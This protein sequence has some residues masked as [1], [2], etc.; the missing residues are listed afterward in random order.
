MKV[1]HHVR[2]PERSHHLFTL[3]ARS[4]RAVRQAARNLQR[5]LGF[6]PEQPL[7]D[8]AHTLHVGQRAFDHRL[9][10]VAGSRSELHELLAEAAVSPWDGTQ[11]AG[12]AAGDARW[13]GQARVAFLFTGQIA[14]YSGMGRSLYESSTLVRHTFDE[15]A[16]ILRTHYPVPFL[17][18]L[19]D[20]RHE[21][22]LQEMHIAQPLQF[23]LQV[24]LARL[25][26]SW[27]VQPEVLIGHS[28]GEFAA[29]C[30]AGS[31]S[32]HDALLLVMR[33]GYLL[34]D[35][36][37]PGVMVSL[38]AD[39]ETV[40]GYLRDF[41]GKL[42]ITNINASDQVVV[43]GRPEH[44]EQLCERLEQM[45]VVHKRVGGTRA[46]HCPLVEPM[47]EEFR[48]H[49]EA[50]SM[51][52]PQIP[53]VSNL[54]GDVIK[55][56]ALD[57]DYWCEHA[58][59]PVRFAKGL[60][61]LMQQGVNVYIEIGQHTVLTRL[62][63]RMLADHGV[64]D[65]A[66]CI[67][68]LRRGED[69][70]QSIL[71][72]LG[73]YW[74]QGGD[75]NW[76]AFDADFKRRR[77]H[78]PTYPFERRSYWIETQ[79]TMSRAVLETAAASE[80]MPV[81][82]D[83]PGE[84]A[85]LT[86]TE[87]V[88][89]GYWRDVIGARNVRPQSH[90]FN[91][92]GD[93]LNMIQVQ[94]RIREQLGIRVEIQ[95]MVANPKLK[96]L[97][98]HVDNLS[99]DKQA[100]VQKTIPVLLDRSNCELSFAQQ[101]MWLLD[102][103]EPGNP[104][105]N[106]ATSVV[107]R[108]ALRTDLLQRGLNEV[109][110]RHESLRTTFTEFNMNP[111]QV[112]HPQLEL[113]MPVVDLIDLAAEE[114]ETEARRLVAEEAQKPFDLTSGPLLRAG[115]VRLSEQEHVLLLTMHHIISD[116]WSLN[117]LVQE[118]LS[119]YQAA[120]AGRET[121]LP[122]LAVQYAD[123]A[124]WQRGWLQ[125]E[126]L[127]EQVGYWKQQLGGQL[128]VL[129]LPT[130]RPRPAVLGSQGRM[131]RF[132][133]EPAL[134]A[135]LHE[136]SR[137][138][139][140]TLHMTLLAAFK[141]LLHRYTGQEDLLVGTPVANRNRSE[142]ERMIGFFV[143]TLVLRTGVT[144][145]M[146]FTDLLDRVR[147]GTLEAYDHQD[148]P[149]EKLVEELQPE[150][151]LSY[152]PLFQVMFDLQKNP[153]A[154]LDVPG[155]SL[156]LLR[157]D[158]GTSKF[159]LTMS[160]VEDEDR[161]LGM[162]TYNTDLFDAATAERM[163]EHFL[164]LL[165]QVAHAPETEIGQLSLLTESERHLVVGEWNRTER[166]FDQ[167]LL[168][169]HLIANQALATPDA[170][171]VVYEDA[172]LTYRE[173][174]EQAN[175][176]AHRL[177]GLGIGSEDLVALCV[178]RSC[179][180][181]V[182]LLGIMKAGAAYVSLD[183]SF[184]EDRISYMLADT[185]APV[186]VTQSSLLAALPSHQAQILLL[187]GDDLAGQS[188]AEPTVAVEPQQAAYVIYTS[189]STGQPK[190]VVIEHRNLLN[191]V[192]SV[193]GALD[194]PSKAS[195]ATV[196]TLAADLGNTSIF[197]ALCTG[198]TLHVLSQERVSNADAMAEYM[199]RHPI[200]CLKIVPSHFAALMS[201]ALQRVLPKQRLIFGGEALSWQ[202]VEQISELAPELA[203][204][205][206]YG[207]TETTVGVLTHRVEL[208]AERRSATVPLGRPLPN[209]QVYLLDP[210]GQPLPPGIAGEVHVGGAQ[211]TRGYLRRDELT[212]EKYIASPLA[213][214]PGE[215]LYKTG[216][217][218]R[219]LPDGKLE[220]I[221]RIDDQVKIR[222]FRVELG[223]IAS[224]I[225][226]SA[227]VRE[228]AMLV[229][230][231]AP[232]DKRLVAYFVPAE[233][234]EPDLQALRR[235]LKEQLPDYMVP[236]AFVPLEVLPLTSNGK[237]DRRALPAPE[238]GRDELA[239]EYVAPRNET[240]ERLVRIW[241]DVLRLERIGVLDNF[242]DLGGH[243]LLGTQVISRIRQEFQVSVPLRSLFEQPTVAFLAEV[244]VKAQSQDGGSSAAPKIA[245]RSRADRRVR[246]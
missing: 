10:V 196:S 1:D 110:A 112:I 175:R 185:A 134:A 120:E 105:Y 220:Y 60:Q 89:A 203:V 176:V 199:E 65:S 161:V 174:N 52:E 33:R 150:R 170:V 131:H 189:G 159:D 101:R 200:D 152:T 160:L 165:E 212:S 153:L 82:A 238:G 98:Q 17:E 77:V 195:Y 191:Y 76:R 213:A 84:A 229:R 20:E 50:V 245:A 29:A 5:H 40:Q 80:V 171:A 53:L 44:I 183:P 246:R 73:A 22:S 218:A 119:L 9:A 130:D 58:R 156:E 99:G 138:A 11:S 51:Q 61:R 163:A 62:V 205:N 23:M 219:Y 16:E 242:F 158:G 149:F 69:A 223:E 214:A 122:Q 91:L 118:M 24:A 83:H 117:V 95:D 206:H 169:P 30:I 198:S 232:G 47:M 224:V 115:L 116:G 45:E 129:Q 133:I 154:G 231:D 102:Q 90:F 125:G 167:K 6:E 13:Q 111:V 202:L 123:F 81:E 94:T 64:S 48:S 172:Q 57:A 243:S 236:S 141:A 166:A 192:Q 234:V 88:I 2:M 38:L 180:M 208:D 34:N 107:L 228:V 108:G 136:Q 151:N 216:D 32:L 177:I 145:E 114:R 181:I 7:G 56:R 127:E 26:M 186:F 59:Q 36:C 201:V 72:H 142:I 86:E 85:H 41:E 63:G 87:L 103:L 193:I 244:I 215:R 221:G 240:E 155:L 28:L 121:T 168:V 226:N 207:P 222:G 55:G 113:A 106:I 42:W 139:G 27:G 241:A 3:T 54:T 230:E 225:L 126:V 8:L 188:A 194:L 209:V 49:L 109:V 25:W 15:C 137:S 144:G 19:F 39:E 37:E 227:A 31:M 184:P 71:A 173:L 96:D 70:W 210:N 135:R 14:Q 179:D 68:S 67:G 235:E 97:A 162:V 21:E 178:E 132:E 143:N 100:A 74:A 197:P 217:L 92:G 128:P 146:K 93:S 237:V 4:D 182:G 104:A 79:R 211:V 46:S 140:A 157:A 204:Y 12:L 18:Y 147:R 43:S 78:V 233:G 124:H 75:V 66:L 148:L 190:G 187:D 239:T 164:L 35:R